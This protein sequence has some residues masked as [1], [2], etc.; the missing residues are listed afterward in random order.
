M[1]HRTLLYSFLRL[2]LKTMALRQPTKASSSVEH[3][4]GCTIFSTFSTALACI[5]RINGPKVLKTRWIHLADWLAY[6]V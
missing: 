5:W 4:V 6:N 2:I 1:E 3:L